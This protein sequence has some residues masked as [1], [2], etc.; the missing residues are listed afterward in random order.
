LAIETGI[1]RAGISRWIGFPSPDG[2]YLFLTTTAGDGDKQSY[3]IDGQSY[4]MTF[5]EEFAAT[6]D[7]LFQEDTPGD[8]ATIN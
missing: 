8:V 7:K 2:H 4:Q 1:E 6:N 5:I 3:V